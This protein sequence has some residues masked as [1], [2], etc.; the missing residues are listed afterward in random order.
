[1]S[2]IEPGLV[3]KIGRVFEKGSGYPYEWRHDETASSFVIF[4]GRRF[5]CFS[6]SPIS[7]NYSKRLSATIA[8]ADIHPTKE[9]FLIVVDDE[10]LVF[11]FHNSTPIARLR[12]TEKVDSAIFGPSGDA[13]VASTKDRLYFWGWRTQEIQNRVPISLRSRNLSRAGG[14]ILAFP[15]LKM[16]VLDETGREIRTFD[17]HH[18]YSSGADR[19]STRYVGD[20]P[21]VETTPGYSTSHDAQEAGISA[22]GSLVVSGDNA[23]TI[24]CW[25]LSDGKVTFEEKGQLLLSALPSGLIGV[26]NKN[27]VQV[28]NWSGQTIHHCKAKSGTWTCI[29][30]DAQFGAL[31]RSDRIFEVWDL[32]VEKCVSRLRVPSMSRHAMIVDG[33][34]F[35]PTSSGLIVKRFMGTG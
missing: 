18:Y 12:H 19:I 8:D 15:F 1:M 28:L 20:T 32:R 11:Q 31:R 25:N 6:G 24:Y 4:D 17:K 29:S 3:S 9:C 30:P 35:A 2:K 22:D 26:A 7:W 10:V 33:N 14:F 13:I 5:D 23:N 27:H 16:H 21:Y 34:V